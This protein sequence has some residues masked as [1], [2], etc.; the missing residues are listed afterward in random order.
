MEEVAGQGRT[1]LF[2]S[3]NIPMVLNLCQRGILLKAGAVIQDGPMSDVVQTYST[4]TSSRSCLPIGERH[5]RGGSGKIIVTRIAFLDRNGNPRN[6][7][8]T[9]QH[10]T[11]RL[12]YQCRE[13]GSREC[14][15][16]LSLAR[17][18]VI[19][20]VLSTWTSS[21]DPLYFEGDGY[22]D[23]AIDKLPLTVGDYVIDCFLEASELYDVVYHA[24][25]ISVTEGDYFKTGRVLPSPYWRDVGVLIEHKI[26][27]RVAD[28]A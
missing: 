13:A 21:R 27:H 25:T 4:E 7:H 14:R 8:S 20:T 6:H 9:G 3:H 28:Y 12:H 2:V 16:G 1:V 18:G 19:F 23:F 5:D 15:A 24:A 11:V 17:G 10:L 22:V 26:L